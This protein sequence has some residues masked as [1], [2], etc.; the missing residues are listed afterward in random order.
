MAS[1]APSLDASLFQHFRAARDRRRPP[2]AYPLLVGCI[3]VTA[4][5]VF[6]MW[7]KAIWQTE[8]LE[9]P[10]L[11]V[12]LALA[13]SPP[14][15]P[16]P[17]PGG[18]KPRAAVITPRKPTVRQLVQPVRIEQ[19]PPP[20]TDTS[21]QVGSRDGEDGGQIDGKPDGDPFGVIDSPTPP[22][23]PEQVKVPQVPKIVPPTALEASRIAGE[24]L[25]APDDVTKIA[26]E[27]SGKSRLVGTFKVCLTESGGIA[28]V[29]ALQPTGFAAYDQRIISTIVGTWR[30]RPF[31]IDGKA[32]PVCTAVTFIYSQ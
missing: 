23:P 7:A 31:M 5:I 13:P 20:T 14:P 9:R 24:K 32:A 3:A 21:E 12:D 8:Q 17:P 25:I 11:S 2:W 18:E 4:G 19:P 30:Y 15:P 27:R 22:E 29:T 6:A 1:T 10:K 26:I 28:G 16:P